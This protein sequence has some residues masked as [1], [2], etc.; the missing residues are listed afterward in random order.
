MMFQPLLLR[1]HARV[2]TMNDNCSCL[3][4]MTATAMDVNEV[5]EDQ[6]EDVADD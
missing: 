4:L 3:F 2:N 1:E 6:F 5:D